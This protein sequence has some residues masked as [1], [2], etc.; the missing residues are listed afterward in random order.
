[1]LFNNCSEVMTDVI[2]KTPVGKIVSNIPVPEAQRRGAGGFQFPIKGGTRDV[3]YR[4]NVGDFVKVKAKHSHRYGVGASSYG[5]GWTVVKRKVSEDYF[6]IWKIE[7]EGYIGARLRQLLNKD[8]LDDY[9]V[10][11]DELY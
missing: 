11:I 6:G 10:F 5:D 7:R 8:K 1:M 4:M 2:K 9:R 3:L